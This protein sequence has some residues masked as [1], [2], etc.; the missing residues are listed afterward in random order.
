METRFGMINN[1]KDVCDAITPNGEVCRV[2]NKS[3]RRE[4][5]TAKSG[6]TLSEQK[7]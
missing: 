3:T 1:G 7:S 6:R 5:T 2:L 4:P